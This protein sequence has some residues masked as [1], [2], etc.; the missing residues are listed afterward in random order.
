MT[1]MPLPSLLDEYQFGLDTTRLLARAFDEAWEKIIASRSSL[2][3][4]SNAADARTLLAIWLIDKT[5]AGEQDAK[6]LVEGAL[7][8]MAELALPRR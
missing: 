7:A 1:V 3:D 8:Y 6:R 2:A 4:G 5:R